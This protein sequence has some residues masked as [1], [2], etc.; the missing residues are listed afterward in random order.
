MRGKTFDREITRKLGK[1]EHGEY[2]VKLGK[3]LQKK[4]EISG[5]FDE[6]KASWKSKLAAADLEIERLAKAVREGEET[7]VVQC[8]EQIHEQ[9]GK[10]TIHRCDDDR[11]V[12]ERPLT[13]TERQGTLPGINNPD[14]E[15]DDPEEDDDDDDDV[16]ERNHVPDETEDPEAPIA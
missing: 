7:T 13:L 12:D 15:D 11:Q 14:E 6:V 10:A 4:H 8:Y 1:N 2:G 5:D 9:L 16:P 3:A